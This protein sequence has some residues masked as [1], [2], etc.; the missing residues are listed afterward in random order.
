MWK[1]VLALPT[2]APREVHQALARAREQGKR[3]EVVQHTTSKQYGLA[4]VDMVERP[5]DLVEPDVV[6]N[7]NM[8][9][10]AAEIG[11]AH[12]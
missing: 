3:V 7:P 9:D 10:V 1:R 12:V 6:V 2:S 5:Q 8:P 4:A 11:R